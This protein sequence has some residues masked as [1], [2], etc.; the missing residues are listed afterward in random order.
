[1]FNTLFFPIIAASQ[2]CPVNERYVDCVNFCNTCWE[3][4]YCRTPFCRPGCDCIPGFYR[5]YYG[6]CVTEEQCYS[7]M[8]GKFK[9]YFTVT[10]HHQYGL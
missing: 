7:T 3:S 2:R 4:G 1:M 9:N 6:E 5:N 8:Y 10:A